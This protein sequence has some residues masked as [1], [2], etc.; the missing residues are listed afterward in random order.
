MTVLI[1]IKGLEGD[2]FFRRLA[3]LVAL[4]DA[5]K[6]LLVH[7][8]DT[9]PREHLEMGRGRFLERRPL[10]PERA[11]ELT[12]AEEER[13]RA[14]LQTARSALEREGVA[15][16]HVNEL[17]LRGHANE[18]LRDLAERESADLIV[19]AGRSSKPGPHSIGKTARFLIDHC[20][21]AALVIRS[22][23]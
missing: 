16:D 3:E 10:G 4:R 17:V 20:P 15:L 21:H 23:R 14:A 9:G 11:G 12:R 7:V 5:E 19:V 18:V 22:D 13:G 1:A 2:G 8:I 6:I